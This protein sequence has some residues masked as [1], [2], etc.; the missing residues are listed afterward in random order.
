MIELKV[1]EIYPDLPRG[2]RTKTREKLKQDKYDIR[3]MLE[4]I[5][6]SED[7]REEA[8]TL[9]GLPAR[10]LLALLEKAARSWS[11]GNAILLTL[12]EHLRATTLVPKELAF[13]GKLFYDDIPKFSSLYANV[14]CAKFKKRLFAA[15]RLRRIQEYEQNLEMQTVLLLYDAEYN[16]NIISLPS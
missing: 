8:R 11:S 5:I 4:D 7:L 9:E 10:H 12:I 3:K 16:S 14:F 6:D 15:K 13:R 1:V 2:L